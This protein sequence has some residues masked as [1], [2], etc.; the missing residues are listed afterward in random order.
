VKGGGEVGGGEVGGGVRAGMVQK[1]GVGVGNE[2]G[3]GTE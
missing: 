1:E 2:R 3:E